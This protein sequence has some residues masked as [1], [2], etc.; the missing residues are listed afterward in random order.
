MSALSAVL[1]IFSFQF[2][3]LFFYVCQRGSLPAYRFTQYRTSDVAENLGMYLSCTERTY[4]GNDIELNLTV[5]METRHL[6]DGSVGSEFRAI[7]NH[8]V[9]MAA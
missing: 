8:R 9:V 7:C 3:L 5:K 6:V 4:Q 2:S 1:L